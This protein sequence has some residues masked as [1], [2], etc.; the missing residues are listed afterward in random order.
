M[1]FPGSGDFENLSH[2]FLTLLF[3]FPVVEMVAEL[4]E[5][6]SMVAEALEAI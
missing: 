6:S 4:V 2:R 5:V 3:L 1:R